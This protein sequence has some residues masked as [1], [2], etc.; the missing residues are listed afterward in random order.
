LTS[1]ETEIFLVSKAKI[2]AELPA[3]PPEDRM[4][5]LQRLCEFQE[6]DLLQG[7]G[8]TAEDRKLL[9]DALAEFERDRRRGRLWRE[10]LQSIR[11]SRS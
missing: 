11:T 5:V 2:L 8:P 6:N 4:L 1:L 9:D 7:I 3:L 10:V